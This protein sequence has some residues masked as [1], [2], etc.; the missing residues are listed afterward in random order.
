MPAKRGDTYYVKRNFRGVGKVTRSLRTKSRNRAITL[1]SALISLHAQGRLD[2]VRAFADGTLSIER[3]GEAYESGKIA[4]ISGQ[5]RDADELLSTAIRAA[6]RDKAPDVRSS[7]LERYH[8]GLGHFQTFVGDVA[9]VRSALLTEIIQEFKSH[10]FGQGVSKETINNDLGAISILASYSLACGWLS[11]RPAI[12]RF[13]SSVRIRYLEPD[14]ITMYMAAL[15]GPFRPLFQLLVGSG[16]RLGEAEALRA[17]DLRFGSDGARALVQDAKT[18]AG[19]RAVFLPPWVA[20]AL[21][22]WIERRAISGSD[23]LF[24]FRR[25]TVQAEHSRARG[26]VGLHEYTIHDHRHTAAVHMARVGMP[27]NLIQQQLG[28]ANISQTMRYACFHPDY[29]D[30]GEYFQRIEQRFGLSSGHKPG[31]S[32]DPVEN[33]QDM[34]KL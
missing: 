10:R 24:A 32:P 33:S 11:E 2:V 6:L 28:H 17:C 13:R 14:Q 8:T 23:R 25:R 18:P 19:N 15:R 34:R 16:M 3:I 27:L 1:E 30:Y 29:S 20:S 5:L 31:H 4:E 12:R 9:T 26:I 7:T 21:S 22:D